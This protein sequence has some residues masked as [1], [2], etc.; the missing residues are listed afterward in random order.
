MMTNVARN[1]A[2]IISKDDLRDL[3]LMLWM[4]DIKVINNYKNIKHRNVIFGP[5]IIAVTFRCSDEK[6]NK[7]YEKMDSLGMWK[8]DFI[9]PKY[10]STCVYYDDINYDIENL[11]NSYLIIG[12]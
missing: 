12:V 5:D 4:Y 6:Y 11:H 9:N 8:G 2:V 7:I 3:E 10:D 1:R